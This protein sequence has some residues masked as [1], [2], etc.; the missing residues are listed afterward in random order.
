M[1]T[2]D[3]IKKDMFIVLDGDIAQ[4]TDRKL[5]T[6]GRQGGLI[7]FEAKKVETGQIINQTVKAGT[8]FEY[9]EPSYKELQFL[10]ADDQL[11]F[12][13]TETFENISVSKDLVDDYIQYMKEGERY[14]VLFHDGKALTLRKNRSVELEVVESVDAVK[15]NTANSATK[16]VTT[17][18]G[19]RLSVPLFVN[20]G[21]K[22]TVNTET[23]EYTGRVS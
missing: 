20:K 12:M 16:M 18:T 11:Y 4:V 15:G 22:I 3:Q 5:K 7:I 21:D 1:A 23:G 2:T 10:Y 19:Y 13:E 9:I 17:D 8:K 6:Q 14:V